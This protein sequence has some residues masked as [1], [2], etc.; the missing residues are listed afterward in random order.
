MKA[1]IAPGDGD[2]LVITLNTDE[3]PMVTTD[4]ALR[5]ALPSSAASI[6]DGILAMISQ[7]PEPG[8]PRAVRVV[9]VRLARSVTVAETTI[10]LD[11]ERQVWP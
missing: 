9:T 6:A 1:E 11:A 2:E 3:L 4:R 7:A 8:Q 10:M 5:D